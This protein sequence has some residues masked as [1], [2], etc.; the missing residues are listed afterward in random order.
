MF[1]ASVGASL[2]LLAVA[3][4]GVVGSAQPEA[5]S[6][7]ATIAAPAPQLSRLVG[8]IDA[9]LVLVNPET[10]RSLPGKGIAVGSGGCA[11]RQGGS[12]CWSNPPWTVSPDGARLALARNDLSSLQ[13][14]DAGRLRVTASVRLSGGP[15]GALA[16]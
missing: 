7:P 1:R 14:V 3:T 2:G 8:F 9:R 13:V 5:R 11:S 10:L 4:L 15:I 6:S 16:W 12:A